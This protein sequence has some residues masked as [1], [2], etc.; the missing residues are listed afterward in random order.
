MNRTPN[1][2]QLARKLGQMAKANHNLRQQQ[3]QMLRLMQIEAEAKAAHGGIV[4]RD[5][6]KTTEEEG[7]GP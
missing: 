4:L 3:R 1:V 6:H 2:S 7:T 5:T